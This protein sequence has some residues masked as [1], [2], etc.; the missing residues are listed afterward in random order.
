MQ[1]NVIE[2]LKNFNSNLSKEEVYTKLSGKNVKV[3][4][5]HSDKFMSLI[6]QDLDTGKTYMIDMIE[7]AKPG[8]IRVDESTKFTKEQEAYLVNKNA[9]NNTLSLKI[10]LPN[11]TTIAV[12]DTKLAKVTQIPNLLPFFTELMQRHVDYSTDEIQS[13]PTMYCSVK[14]KKCIKQLKELR[15]IRMDRTIMKYVVLNG[16]YEVTSVTGIQGNPWLHNDTE[17]LDSLKQHDPK[18]FIAAY[19]GVWGTEKLDNNVI[20][21]SMEGKKC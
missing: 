20:D 7:L 15:I 21:K 13:L 18:E 4:T 11:S 3:L 14:T 19:Y 9:E 5:G 8:Y 12:N 10:T 1:N 16:V 6:L 17:Y 2:P